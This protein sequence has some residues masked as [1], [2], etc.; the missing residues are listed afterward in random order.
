MTTFFKELLE[1]N[2]HFNQFLIRKLSKNS[3]ETTGKAILL[4]N[5]VINAHQICNSRILNEIAFGVFQ[6]HSLNELK[7]L[8]TQNY[9]KTLE[10]ILTKEFSQVIEYTNT[11]E[12]TFTNSLRDILFHIINHPNYHRAQIATECR[13]NGLKPLVCDYI[14]YNQESKNN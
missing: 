8:N 1:Y 3:G 4:Q 6:I 12:Q 13:Q 2:Y 5:H 9:Q 10:I 11:K 7:Q 14:F